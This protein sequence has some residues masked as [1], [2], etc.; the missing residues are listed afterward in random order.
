MILGGRQTGKTTQVIDWYL[1]SPS[2]RAIVTFSER[3][4][5][6]IR[7]VI[8]DSITAKWALADMNPVLT[9]E[10]PIPRDLGS[11]VVSAHQA[12]HSGLFRGSRKRYVVDNIEHLP[13]RDRQRLLHNPFNDGYTVDPVQMAQRVAQDILEEP[14]RVHE[15]LAI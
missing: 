7:G 3:E 11:S 14:L 8:H 13:W 9:E 1:D 5:H 12:I 4:A 6:R 2:T 10:Q 15:I